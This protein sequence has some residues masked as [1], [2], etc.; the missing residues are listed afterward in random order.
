[1]PTAGVKVLFVG[2]SWAVPYDIRV[3]AKIGGLFLDI[4]SFQ[5]DVIVTSEFIPGALNIS[6]LEVRKRW[7][8]V[9]TNASVEEVTN[10]VNCCYVSNLYGPHPRDSA[11]PLVSIYTGTY[12]TGDLLRDTYQSLRD[13]TY[14]NWEWCVV[15]DE[16]TDGTWDRL[17]QIANEDY[18]V[19]PMRIKHSGKIGNMKDLATRM[20]NGKYLI[21]LDHDDMLTDNAVDEVRKAFDADPEVG[22]VYTN[23]ANFFSDGSPH[24]FTDP[25]WKVRY[26]DTEYRGKVYKEALQ[27]DIYDSFGD[28]YWQLFGYFLTVGPNH[29]RSYRAETLRELGGYNGQ[30]PVADDFDLFARFFLFSKCLRLDKLLYLYRFGDNWTNTTFIRNKAIQDHLEHARNHYTEEYKKYNEKR[31]KLSALTVRPEKI[32]S[33]VVLDWNTEELTKRCLKSVRDNYPQVEI[34]LVQ[35]GKHFEAVGLADR[36]IKLETNIGFAAGCNRGAMEAI[37]EY[38]CFLN[39]D[40]VVDPGLFEALLG[41]VA[42]PGV[43][44][45]GPY[46]NHA[47]PPQGYYN[48]DAVPKDSLAPDSIVAVCLV[49]SRKL[50]EDIGGF[51]PMFCNFEDDDLC[52]R[53]K[54]R[55]LSCVVA[56]GAWIHHEEHASFSANKVDV[57]SKIRGSEQLFKEKWP[58]I[59]V[60]AITLNERRSLPGFM[61]QFK[62]ITSDICLLDSGSTDGTLEWA[63][64]RGIRVEHRKLT[65]FAE[66]RNAAL[67]VFREGADWFIMHDPDERLDNNTLENMWELV[68][69]KDYDIYLS[70]LRA[71]NYDGSYTEWVAKPFLFRAAPEIK[72]VFPVHEKMIG[73]LR[74]ALV[75]NSWNTHWLELHDPDRRKSMADLYDSLG[76]D[77]GDLPEWPI[78]NYNKRDDSR[79]KKIV[80]GP[81]I[82]V[83][84]PTYK[85]KELLRK[86]VDSILAQD[87]LAKEVVVIGDNCPE[88][89]D[90]PGCVCLNLPSNHGAGGAVPRNYGIMSSGSKWI[91]YLDDDNQWKSNH[92]SSLYLAA[93]QSEA[94]FAAS[95]MEVD[96]KVLICD[97]PEFGKIDTSEVLHR[98]ELVRSGWWRNRDEDGYAHDWSFIKRLLDGGAKHVCTLLPTVIYNKQT[99]GQEAFLDKVLK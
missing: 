59:R 22:M 71:K 34:V 58:K 65:N 73:S 87:Y 68:R 90:I 83:I 12:N 91:A 69:A 36:V 70:P 37:G 7:I 18:R 75:T 81:K 88:F 84:V 44:V 57:E 94:N 77:G 42:R 14:P 63:K 30:F 80:L 33:A 62:G 48:K 97:K 2:K 13:Q 52:R 29:I 3:C 56:G 66:Q 51:D 79:I 35:N 96:G 11:E 74:Q 46:C 4:A 19:R 72:W 82:S 85:R 10:S 55:G 64:E 38:V 99:S 76:K 53:V 95:S 6:G 1:M 20:A 41:Q 5:P 16:S 40:T 92:L 61:E 86:A 67:D 60:V 39:S 28:N 89:A 47:K 8:H 26:R 32:L 15:D 54:N 78:I 27:P 21:E 23:C 9:N 25:F 31:L 98:K 24:M 49:I 45:V 50:F 93:A 17:L 43:G